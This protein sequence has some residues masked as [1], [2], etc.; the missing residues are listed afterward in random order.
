[1]KSTSLTIGAK[2]LSEQAKRLEQAGKDE[3]LEYIQANHTPLL[4]L[5][6]EVCETISHV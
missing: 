6:R 5:Y 2:D 1:M 3:D 4:E